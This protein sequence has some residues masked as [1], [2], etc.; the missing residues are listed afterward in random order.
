MPTYKVTRKAQADLIEIGRYT[1]KE[2]GVTQRNTYLKELDNCFSQITENPELGMACDYIANGYRKFPQGSH[3]IFYKQN[4]KNII[5][6]IR[7]LHKSV[8]VVAKFE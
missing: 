2:W 5:E 3:L 7:V 8:D 1:T 4:T 6:I